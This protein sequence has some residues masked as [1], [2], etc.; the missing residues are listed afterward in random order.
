MKKLAIVKNFRVWYTKSVSNYKEAEALAKKALAELENGNY[1]HET[2]Y[3]EK[4]DNIDDVYT[5]TKG[6]ELQAEMETVYKEFSNWLGS[7]EM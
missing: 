7:W 2:K 4:F 5:L 3:I 6:K 1:T